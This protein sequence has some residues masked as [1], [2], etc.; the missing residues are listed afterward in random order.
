[1][2]RV[3]PRR[4]KWTPTDDLAFVGE[5]PLFRPPEQPVMVSCVFTWDILEAR[6]LQASWSQYYSNVMIGGPAF[7]DPGGEFS[8]GMF[9]KDG[10][11]ITSRGCPNRCPWCLVPKREGAIREYA[12]SPGWIIQDNNLLACSLAH[13]S[14]VFE[15]CRKQSK[16][17]FFK[18][19]LESKRITVWHVDQ[20][21]DLRLGEVW[22]ACDTP[23]SLLAFSRAANLL[24]KIPT[25]KKRCF[26]M[27]GYDP[28]ET[29]ETAEN[30]LKAVY[31]AGFLP[32][33]QLFQ[34]DDEIKRYSQDWKSL[35][36]KWSRPAI[37][38]SQNKRGQD[39]NEVV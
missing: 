34:P 29:L 12:I 3:F 2:I 7:G 11:T 4:T 14:A 28:Q 36:R 5:P 38:R 21:C 18:G 32:F 6:R 8:P 31:D 13:Q 30:R 19:G 39:A 24:Y 37:Y 17:I 20:L 10:V 22:L 9:I 33:C 26:V 35:A 23:K 27:V 25:N 16:P 1:M 15:M